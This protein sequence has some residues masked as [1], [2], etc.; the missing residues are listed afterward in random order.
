MADDDAENPTLDGGVKPSIVIDTVLSLYSIFEGLGTLLFLMNKP[1]E[2]RTNPTDKSLEKEKKRR[3][4]KWKAAIGEHL[5]QDVS[6]EIESLVHLRDRCI[7]QDQAD[8]KNETDYDK[9]FDPSAISPHFKLLDKLLRSLSTKHN[10]YPKTP[11]SEFATTI[12]G[13]E[14]F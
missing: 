14:Y 12:K 8:L 6:S 9:T 10:A 2:E 3:R 11:I 7:H 13:S 1:W 4:G 5:K